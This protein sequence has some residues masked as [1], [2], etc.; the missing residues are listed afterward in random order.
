[1]ARD[2]AKKQ[3]RPQDAGPQARPGALPWP[4]VGPG[5]DPTGKT[6][7][8][9]VVGS[10]D[11]W[12]EYTLADGTVLRVKAAVLDVKFAVDQ[13]D[14]DGNPIYLIQTTFV[15]QLKVPDKLKRKK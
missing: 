8:V 10:K 9:D 12:S 7:P 2:G 6:E 4:G 5:F 3:R 15:T 1:M 11:G 13:Y 14:T